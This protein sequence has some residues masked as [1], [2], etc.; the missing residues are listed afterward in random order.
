[1]SQKGSGRMSIQ[2]V[3]L[4][5]VIANPYRHIEKYR[6]S[7]EK[8]EALLRSYASSSFWDGSIQGRESAKRRGKIEI[9]FGHHRVEAA[10][11]AKIDRIGIVVSDRSNEEMIRMMHHENASE[12]KH[13]ALV[14]VEEIETLIDAYSRKE[15]DFGAPPV[16]ARQT[17]YANNMPYSAMTIARFLG[18][19]TADGQATPAFRKAFDA[20]QERHATHDA[21]Q[22]LAPSE[23][24]EVAVQT[25]V[26]A[27]KAARRAAVKRKLDEPQ[28]KRAEKRAADQAA[29]EVKET[30]GFR[31]RNMAVGIGKAASEQVA[32]KKP[33]TLPMM[34][35]Y[36]ARLIE[37]CNTSDP[38]GDIL[39]ECRRLIPYI[40]D[41]DVAL[42][43]K[44]A[45]ALDGMLRRS[46]TGVQSVAKALRT[47]NADKFRQALLEAK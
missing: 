4:K 19:V 11:R 45:D 46:T 40:D 31:A 26:S 20:Y 3:P 23:R 7:E 41:L 36:A 16:N 18:S 14:A 47:G 10:R 27:V 17:Y 32:G 39:T 13:D 12:F 30:G 35:V 21:L 22:T 34:E 33:K 9:A 42:A 44:L 1:M 24:S 2:M 29:K 5:D 6:I 38:Y 25:V 28:I 15:I 43:R 37:K 8:I